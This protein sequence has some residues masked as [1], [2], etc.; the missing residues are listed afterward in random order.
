MLDLE[1]ERATTQEG[2]EKVLQLQALVDRT[3]GDVVKLSAEVKSQKEAVSRLE[4]EKASLNTTVSKLHS[5]DNRE[6][7]F[8]LPRRLANSRPSRRKG[9]GQGPPRRTC[10]LA[11]PAN[12]S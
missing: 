6:S 1:R 5:A 11:G 4:A 2:H 10:C 7:T 8:N 9:T 12:S 3:Q